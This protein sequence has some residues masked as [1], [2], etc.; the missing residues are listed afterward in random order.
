VVDAGATSV[1]AVADG[2]EEV[3]EDGEGAV[4]ELGVVTAEDVPELEVVAANELL[5]V[6]KNDDCDKLCV[7]MAI[8]LVLAPVGET[9]VVNDEDD[10]PAGELLLDCENI[11]LVEGTDVEE[12]REEDTVPAEVFEAELTIL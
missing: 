7:V 2:D 11:M 10:V 3:V 6:E 8:E 4:E 5:D 12:E 9:D 1:D